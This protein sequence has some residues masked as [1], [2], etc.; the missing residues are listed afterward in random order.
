MGETILIKGE[1]YFFSPMTYP[2]LSSIQCKCLETKI[3]TR[4]NW[5]VKLRSQFLS[6]VLAIGM[7]TNKIRY[8]GRYP[9][10]IRARYEKNSIAH[11][12]TPLLRD[13]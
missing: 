12:V 10:P 6:Y 8:R 11:L 5:S 3:A 13:I 7:L 9:F 1:K 2:K 4:V